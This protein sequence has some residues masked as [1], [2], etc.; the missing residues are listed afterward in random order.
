[1]KLSMIMN[2]CIR[3]DK[4]DWRSSD[5]DIQR[6]YCYTC[7]RPKRVCL[8]RFIEIEE[9]KCTIGVLQHP[10]EV[11]KTFNTAKIA[12]L[13]LE[14]SFLFTG[15]NFDDHEGFNK[16]L[17]QFNSSKVGVLYPSS[18]AIDLKNAPNDLECL[19]IVDGTWPEAKKILKNTN[20]FQSIQHYA[21]K[22][23]VV[24]SYVLRKE[25]DVDYVCSLEAVVESLR[26]L[27]NDK[28]AYQSLLNTLDKMI[29]MQE[30]FRHSNSRHK[31]SPDYTKIKK[32]IKEINRQL[33]SS[34]ISNLNTKPLL[35]ELRL[36]KIK[37]E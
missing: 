29:L 2:K 11:G 1:M 9:N 24:S 8:C 35:E 34:N 31:S 19:I 6:G 37:V 10:N 4:H 23:Q 30:S 28:V 13:S 12:Q 36:L 15:I 26:I 22:P 25:P 32:R 21:F 16:Q 27:E 3:P 7:V 14:K 20:C 5:K 18:Q 17:A 33:Y